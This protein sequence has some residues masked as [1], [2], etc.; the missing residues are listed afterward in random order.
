MLEKQHTHFESLHRNNTQAL[1]SFQSQTTHQIDKLDEL[2]QGQTQTIQDSTTHVSLL[3]EKVNDIPTTLAASQAALKN[4]LSATLQTTTT[5]IFKTMY[6]AMQNQLSLIS[7]VTQRLACLPYPESPTPSD[8][9]KRICNAST[10]CS[11]TQS[12]NASTIANTSNPHHPQDM[13]LSDDRAIDIPPPSLS[14][15]LKLNREVGTYNCLLHQLVLLMT[16][17]KL[18][19]ENNSDYGCSKQPV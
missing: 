9:H 12:P 13:D 1:A 15:C 8:S 4:E 6:A 19:P 17:Y 11:Q 14:L 3:Q 5:Q 10:S 16:I 2:L 7:Q 18:L